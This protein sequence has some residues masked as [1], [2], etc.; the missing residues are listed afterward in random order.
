ML[1][2]GVVKAERPCDTTQ[3]VCHD[4]VAQRART[5][6]HGS[7]HDRHSMRTAESTIGSRARK[8]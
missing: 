2:S 1:R 8:Q 3:Q 7:V 6:V 4:R 5:N